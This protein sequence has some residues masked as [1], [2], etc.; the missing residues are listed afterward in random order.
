MEAQSIAEQCK[1]LYLQQAAAVAAAEKQ[2][3]EMVGKVIGGVVAPVVAL[4]VAPSVILV[5]GLAVI[6]YGGVMVGR[7]LAANYHNHC[8]KLTDPEYIP[9]SKKLL[10]D[11]AQA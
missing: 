7:E 5:A 11:P 6:G 10:A 4:K 9:P 2:D 3:V 8:K 1:Q